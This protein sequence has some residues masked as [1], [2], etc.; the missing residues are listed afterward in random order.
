MKS[1]NSRSSLSIFL[2][3]AFLLYL[4]LVIFT[5]FHH[6]PWRDEVHALSI[7]KAA[8]SLPGLFHEFKNEGHPGITPNLVKLSK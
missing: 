4:A 7:A 8:R 5:S 3:S 1:N 6:V 2:I